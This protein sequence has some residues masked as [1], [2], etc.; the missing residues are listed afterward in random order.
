MFLL[1]LDYLRKAILR[2]GGKDND[3][4]KEYK[5]CFSKLRQ[6]RTFFGVGKPLFLLYS[7]LVSLNLFAMMS[8]GDRS[9][10][11]LPTLRQIPRNSIIPDDHNI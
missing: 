2:I 1:S 4:P 10:K 7:A 8:L 11:K 9:N 3:F 6:L 5:I